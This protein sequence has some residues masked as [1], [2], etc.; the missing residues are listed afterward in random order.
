M[1]ADLQAELE[2]RTK[3]LKG[4][5]P[6]LDG[7]NYQ[8]SR[9]LPY[10]VVVIDEI[11]N[12]MLCRDKIAL[13]EARSTAA[14]APE[15]IL[16]DLAA[17]A[18]AVGIHLVVSIQQ[19]SVNVVTVLIKANSPC[20]TAFGAASEVDSRLIIDDGSAHGASAGRMR[21]RRNMELLELQAPFLSDADIRRQVKQIIA[22]SSRVLPAPETEEGRTRKEIAILQEIAE[23]GFGRR[24][25]IRGLAA[26]ATIV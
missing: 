1:L 23:R 6:D 2:R 17:R 11:A 15:S 13:G 24:F 7:D 20:R 21:Y 16:A 9:A 5:V 26:H 19:P 22:D 14:A 4:K 3:L 8:V 18:R 12:A 25:P 10:I